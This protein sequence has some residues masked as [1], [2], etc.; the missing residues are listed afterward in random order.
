MRRLTFG[1]VAVL[2]LAASAAWQK[3]GSIQV[4][5]AQAFTKAVMKLGENADRGSIPVIPTGC[6][7]LDAALGVGGWKLYKWL[8]E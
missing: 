2:S 6:L 1:I 4:A 5:D 3:A 7:T 8:S